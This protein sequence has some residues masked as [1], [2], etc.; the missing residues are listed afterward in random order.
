MAFNLSNALSGAG[1]ALA[2]VGGEMARTEIRKGAELD[3][4]RERSAIEE[5]RNARL[6]ELR[7]GIRIKEADLDAARK[8]DTEQRLSPILL[9]RE[10]AKPR[11]FSEGQTYDPG[12]GTGQQKFEKTPAPLSPEE[13]ALRKSE[14]ELRQKQGGLVDAQTR[15]TDAETS[16]IGAGTRW[17]SQNPRPNDA[18]VQRNVS[19]ALT[20]IDKAFKADV[21]DL[22]RPKIDADSLPG[23][24]EIA[25]LLVRGGM[26]P[27]EAANAA[28]GAP[29]PSRKTAEAAAKKDY[30]EH[31]DKGWGSSAS[32]TIDGNKMTKDEYIKARTDEYMTRSNR[33]FDRWMKQNGLRRSGQATR[34]TESPS[35]TGSAAPAPRA[36]SDEYRDNEQMLLPG[37]VDRGPDDGLRDRRI[38]G[39]INGNA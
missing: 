28:I 14:G 31:P 17:G 21:D 24:K 33:E 37:M 15:R 22:G 12:D 10:R 8:V 35:P 34:P 32:V 38:R 20:A 16:A 23:R 39:L 5:A 27:E 6:E 1:G 30:A 18:Q 19:A 25:G 9:E 36:A 3:L 7:S 29:V 26:A 4:M 2:E 13:A 11:T